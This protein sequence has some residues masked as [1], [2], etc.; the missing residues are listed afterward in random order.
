MPTVSNQIRHCT[1]TLQSYYRLQDFCQSLHNQ[2]ERRKPS[3]EEAAAVVAV[4]VEV[5]LVAEE[6]IF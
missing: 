4:E 3:A 1:S 2:K 6:V 5:V